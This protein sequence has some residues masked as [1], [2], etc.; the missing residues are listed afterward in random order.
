MRLLERVKNAIS[1]GKVEFWSNRPE[2]LSRSDFDAFINNTPDFSQLKMDARESSGGAHGFDGEDHVFKGVAAVRRF[3]RTEEFYLKF[4]FWK[5][6][7]PKES[8]GI[9]VQSFKRNK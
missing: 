3:G 4:F 9:E 2:N 5:K 6:N 1:L 7:D 8:Q